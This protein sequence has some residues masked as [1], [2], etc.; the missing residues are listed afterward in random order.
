[1]KFSK[2]TRLLFGGAASIVVVGV[3]LL[4]GLIREESPPKP[5]NSPFTT[6]KPATT[7]LTVP[8]SPASDV[9][10]PESISK[11]ESSTIS[12][13]RSTPSPAFSPSPSDP[14]NQPETAEPAVG[15]NLEP[16][17]R[18]STLAQD[19]VEGS[20]RMYQAHAPLRTASFAN[21]DSVE[22]RR[23]LQTMLSKALAK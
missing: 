5:W 13:H 12:T 7:A 19:Q 1:M 11:P 22:N 6:T 17:S 21:P 4:I 14:T 9:T 16:P 23:V 8:P 18:S 15:P 10:L 20:R 3:W 2:S